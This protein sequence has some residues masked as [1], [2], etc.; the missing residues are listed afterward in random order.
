MK[1][2][3]GTLS[4][5]IQKLWSIP[6]SVQSAADLQRFMLQRK[7]ESI[8]CDLKGNLVSLAAF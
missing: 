2:E 7:C 3:F 4:S 1:R 5:V 6:P 8:C